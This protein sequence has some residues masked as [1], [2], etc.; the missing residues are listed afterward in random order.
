[1]SYWPDNPG[2]AANDEDAAMAALYAEFAE[3]DRE[4]AKTGMAGY[5]AGLE[6][7]EKEL[8]SP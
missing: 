2:L 6:R 3:E 7:E 4:L 5:A 1:M 8:L